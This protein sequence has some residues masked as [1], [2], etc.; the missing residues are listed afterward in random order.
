[1]KI[2]TTLLILLAFMLTSTHLMSQEK[3]DFTIKFITLGNCYTCKVRLEAKLSTVEGVSSSNYDISQ[4]QLSV[5]YD[6]LITDAYVIMQAVADTGHD[7]E[8]FRAPDEAYE[9]LIGTCCEYDRTIDYSQVE[10]GYLSLMD[11]WMGHVAINEKDPVDKTLVYP[12]IS[13]GKYSLQINEAIHN[14]QLNIHIYSISGALIQSKKVENNTNQLVDI[15]N[16]PNGNYIL[17]VSDNQKIIS[18]TKIIKH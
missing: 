2:K 15:S 14:N 16:M 4:D 9:L 5:T 8:W 7:T 17:T 10:I 6:D 1:M 13:Q 3:D 18:K 11:L 12:T